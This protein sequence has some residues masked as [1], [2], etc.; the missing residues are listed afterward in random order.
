M[1]KAGKEIYI[2]EHAL[3]R[4][5]K[6]G[7]THGEVKKTLAEG[8]EVEA[9]YGRKAKE[10]IFT[11]NKEWQ[12]RFYPEK[13]VKV[14]YTEEKQSIVVITVYVYFGKWGGGNEDNL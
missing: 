13:K 5:R 6:R 3:E 2:I 10:L 7:A 9:K 1:K 14:V 12:N 8:K 4:T 11:Y